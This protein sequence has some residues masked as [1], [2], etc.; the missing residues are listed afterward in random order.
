MRQARSKSPFRFFKSFRTRLTLILVLLMLFIGA[1][2]N[3][4]IYQYAI[5]EQFQ[6]IRLRLK[7]IATTASLMIDGDKLGKIP[8]NPG[9]VDTSEFRDIFE[10]LKRIKDANKP[11]KYIYT[12]ARTEKPGILKFI[13]DAD[14]AKERPSE[15]NN[16]YPGT[17]YDASRFAAMID[18]FYGPA[19]DEKITRDQWG[20]FL[21][22]YAPVYDSLG[23]I[24]AILGIDLKADD[25]YA[26]QK[27][28]HQ[29]TIMV[30]ILG[31]FLSFILALFFS[32]RITRS[33]SKL[34]EA[35]RYIS[36]GVLYKVDVSGAE[37]MQQ[38]AKAFNTMAASLDESKKNLL[39]YF[40]RVVQSLIRIL[41]AKDPYTRGH[42]ERVSEYS[43]K[44]ALKLGFPPIKAELIKE[45]AMLHDIGKLAI[46]DDILNKKDK[47]S[48]GDWEQIK[49]H[50]VIGED[51]LK[52]I[53]ITEEMMS[54]VRQHHERYDGKGYP[55]K[56]EGNN[57][58][59]Y[60][61]IVSVADAYDAMTSQRAY[62]DALTKEE[63]V[64]EMLKNRGSQFSPEVVDILIKILNEENSQ[65]SGTHT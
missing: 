2:S 41:E 38:L 34:V 12:M 18:S 22:G 28:V 46:H 36:S 40:Y 19:A 50:P 65:N 45:I 52:P 4:L 59:I 16:S 5:T 23:K 31:I 26:I 53:L 13:V 47:L 30:L 44:I 54:I 1:L 58:N 32:K 25:V 17:E 33:L 6:S 56:I 62:R 20:Y 27:G 10:Q 11:I 8:L 49:Q 24:V 61:S 64:G 60:A 43:E 29:R 37:E 39:N 35:T 7:V 48:S 21:S 57:L 51:I 42:S 15:R 9:G 55:D 63:A 3:L 14:Y